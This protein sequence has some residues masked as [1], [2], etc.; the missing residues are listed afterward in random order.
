[1]RKTWFYANLE[2]FDN[3]VF[4]TDGTWCYREQYNPRDYNID[5]DTNPELFE[6]ALGIISIRE[7][8][9]TGLLL[10]GYELEHCEKYLTIK[11]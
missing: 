2:K 4:Y 1:M 7:D 11:W 3:I 8:D 6:A 10:D 9:E 5:L